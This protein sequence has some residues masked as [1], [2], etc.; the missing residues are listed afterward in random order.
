MSGVKL[1]RT[2]TQEIGGM[3][4]DG[5]L[6]PGDQLPSVRALS[7][8]RKVSPATVLKAY[9][10]LEAS[11]LVEARPRS[12]YYVRELQAQ[13]MLPRTSRPRTSSTR[14][15]VS[16]LVFET[17]E[18][19]RNREVVPLGSAF[20][21]PMQFPWPKLARFLGRS[22]RHLD[23][24]S[25]VES[26]PPGSVDLRRQIAKRYMSLGMSVGIDQIIVTA[27]ALEALNLALQC[28]TRPG[29]TIAIESPTFYGCLQAAQR[30]G[31]NVVEIPMHPTDGLDI[32]ALKAA[33]AKF[34]IRACWFMTTLQH[35]TGATLPRKRK[36]ELVR[37]L[38]SHGIPLI[39]DDAYAELQF[40]AKA[41]P[42]AKAFDRSGNVLHCGSF[43]KCLAPGYRLGWV[44]A[45]R[46]AE[47]LSR[48]KMEASIATSLPVQQGIALMLRSG[49]YDAHLIS[50]RR[51]LAASQRAALDS[52]QRYFP[53]AYRVAAPLGGYFLWVE[54]AAAVDSLDLHRR[55]LD[56][57]ISI[58]PGPIFSARQ[59]FKNFLR[60]NTGHP[61]TNTMAQAIQKLAQLLKRY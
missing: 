10:A 8:S 61:W 54:C 43:S 30:L 46:Y 33:I 3:I 59:Q 23:P 14:L 6:T 55:A 58:A 51:R 39:E 45:G 49:G 15:T 42:P 12:G 40:A 50:L 16:D 9:E 29:D 47:E 32:E 24:W 2:V 26:L 18:A 5:S 36:S 28:V 1:Y 38:E 4:R 20:P 56:L 52:L 19:S 53:T 17:L 13:P 11:G 37:L 31:L 22:A 48:R 35:P 44:A 41:E 21:S 27:G 60:L 34:P 57:G 7:E 25:T